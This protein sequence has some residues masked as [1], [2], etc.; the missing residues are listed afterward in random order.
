MKPAKVSENLLKAD[1]D[2]SNN[3]IDG[4]DLTEVE[5]QF[6]EAEGWD[7]NERYYV[8]VKYD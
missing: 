1:T 4:W 3:L 6:I 7:Y 2:V 8:R 5:R